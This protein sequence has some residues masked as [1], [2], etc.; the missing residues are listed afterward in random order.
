MTAMK[1]CGLQTIEALD[2][3]ID[4]RVD[5]A[6]F[7]FAPSTRRVSLER[8]EQL[9]KRAQGRIQLVGVFVNP[10]V[11]EVEE[12]V[13]R[14]RLDA[15]QLHGDET[16]SLIDALVARGMTVWKACALRTTEDVERALQLKRVSMYVF[17]APSTTKYRG[18]SGATF[19]WTLVQSVDVPFLLAGGLTAETVGEAICTASP[20]GVDVSS[21]LEVDGQKDE[22]RMRAFARAVREE[23]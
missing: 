14:A 22:A 6:G 1:W 11:E 4:E 7:M 5:Y 15:V 10:T 8:A 2:V 20:Y 21:G 9:A 19:D 16:Q 17:D 23:R 18:G 13:R 12:A 3:A